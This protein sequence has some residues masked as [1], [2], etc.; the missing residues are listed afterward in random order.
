MPIKNIIVAKLSELLLGKVPDWLYEKLTGKTDNCQNRCVVATKSFKNHP[1]AGLV[2]SIRIEDVQAG[3]PAKVHKVP[4]GSSIKA[5]GSGSATVY[6]T[7]SPRSLS[8]Q[9]TTDSDIE[10]STN[11]T[12]DAWATG[13][14]A[15]NSQE[16]TDHPVETV[17]LVVSSGTWTL[18]I[19]V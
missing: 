19:A 9:D 8:D 15:G 18:E 3:N 11:A 6:T 4:K 2:E 17:A 5:V 7:T 13:A 10:N 12:W 16:T 1:V 14:A